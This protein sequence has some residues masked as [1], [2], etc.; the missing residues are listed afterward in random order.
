MRSG[1]LARGFAVGLL[2]LA[3]AAP[4]AASW[5]AGERPADLGV[6]RGR[7]KPP[8][9]TENSVSSQATLYSGPGAD[10]ARIAPL[11]L[12]GDP[13]T[14]LQ[15]LAQIVAA[16]PGAR[17]VKQE[18]HYLYAEF[19]SRWLGFVDDVEF[20]AAPAE[21]VIH[22]RSASRMGRR[23]FGVNRARIEALRSAFSPAPSPAAR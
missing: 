16:Q 23:D 9:T 6:N 21:G 22:V 19:S 12:H 20:W 1:A 3:L 2:G 18:D 15:R 5:L 14:E 10:Y 17:I 7:L 11:P 8:S 4:V 13:A